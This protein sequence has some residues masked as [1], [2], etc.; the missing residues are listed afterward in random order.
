[1]NV[2]QIPELQ[3]RRTACTLIRKL[4]ERAGRADN[5]AA[6]EQAMTELA[7]ALSRRDYS[8]ARKRFAE[9]W[10][11][12]EEQDAAYIAEIKAEISTQLADEL[13]RPIPTK[14]RQ[15]LRIWYGIDLP[16]GAIYG[17]ALARKFPWLEISL[18]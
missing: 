12:A 4:T 11:S 13:K 5:R 2:E 7:V 9:L 16:V 10:S 1:M 6:L 18:D 14:V 15:N 8:E 3:T 17:E